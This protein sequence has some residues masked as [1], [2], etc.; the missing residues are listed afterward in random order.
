[1]TADRHE[2]LIKIIYFQC[3]LRE[4]F[5]AHK[6]SSHAVFKEKCVGRGFLFS[7]TFLSAHA[8]YCIWKNSEK[9]RGTEN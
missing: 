4:M 2:D 1:M 6:T 9:G 8:F 3:L 5:T 7:P